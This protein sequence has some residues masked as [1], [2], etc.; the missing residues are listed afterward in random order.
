MELTEQQAAEMVKKAIDMAIPGARAFVTPEHCR[1][2][3]QVLYSSDYRLVN[4]KLD[5][6]PGGPRA[7]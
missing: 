4:P 2:V 5:P 1:K 6:A 3:V 7:L